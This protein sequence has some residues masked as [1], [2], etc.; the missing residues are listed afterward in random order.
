MSDAPA[1]RFPLWICRIPGLSSR[2]RIAL[3]RRLGADG[4]DSDAIPPL[5]LEALYALVGKPLKRGTP[6]KAEAALTQAE[7]D[8]RALER[9][10]A[11]ALTIEDARYPALLREIYDPPYLLFCRGELPPREKP[12]CA[13]VGTRKASAAA[14][15]EAYRIARGLAE[16]GVP[17]VSGLALG[18]DA[19]A[20]RG[21]IEGGAPTAAVLGSGVDMIYPLS[22]RGLARRILA[23]GGCIL[24]EYPPGERAFPGH[25]PARNRVIS[26]LARG[27]LVEEAPARSGAL[28]TAGFALEQNRDLWVGQAGIESRQ[29]EGSRKLAADGAKPAASAD[30]ILEEWELK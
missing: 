29:G 22:N 2:E 9:C 16:A 1:G 27:V 26:A 5:P 7:R 28:I 21:C 10:G 15:A 11:F 3:A 13:I 23:N 20:H 30:V 14:L 8:L 19:M 25:F 4:W 18:I 6:W 24:S 12:L 17:V